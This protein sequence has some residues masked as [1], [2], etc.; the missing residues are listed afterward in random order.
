MTC[1]NPNFILSKFTQTQ[2]KQQVIVKYSTH[3][4]WLGW[5]SLGADESSSP[6]W[7][8]SPPDPAKANGKRRKRT[9]N[10]HVVRCYFDFWI[11]EYDVYC[12]EHHGC[13]VLSSRPL[14]HGIPSITFVKSM[15]CS[16]IWLQFLFSESLSPSFRLR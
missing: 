12:R 6:Y 13:L 4:H 2:L 14:V 8:I 16:K 15:M 10:Q 1:P 11:I 5:I 7:I 3:S 9:R